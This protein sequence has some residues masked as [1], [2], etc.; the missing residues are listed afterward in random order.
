MGNVLDMEQTGKLRDGPQINKSQ[1]S[2]SLLPQPSAVL[3]PCQAGLRAHVVLGLLQA[4]QAVDL[5]GV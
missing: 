4:V 1:R 3:F 5:A 2:F